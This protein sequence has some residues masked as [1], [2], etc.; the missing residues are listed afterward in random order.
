MTKGTEQRARWK[1]YI[2]FITA[3]ASLFGPL[4]V[5]AATWDPTPGPNAYQNTETICATL[6][7]GDIASCAGAGDG[8]WAMRF[9][10]GG[11]GGVWFNGDQVA[12]AETTHCWMPSEF[13]REGGGAEPVYG[14]NITD[15]SVAA[16]AGGGPN[17]TLD[18]DDAPSGQWDFEEEET[19]TSTTTT[20]DQTGVLFGLSVMCLFL[21]GWSGYKL[22]CKMA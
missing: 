1:K 15:V 17:S 3:L 11:S 5:L 2:S 22:S 14:E 8:Y 7:A 9:S 10:N 6:E 21:A 20:V 12:C 4:E 13:N 16:Y 19:S 18:S